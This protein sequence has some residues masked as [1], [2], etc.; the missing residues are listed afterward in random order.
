MATV[1]YKDAK[2]FVDGYDVSGDHNELTLEYNS[3]LQDE[4]SFGDSTRIR[5]GGLTTVRVSGSGFWDNASDSLV[6]DAY[7]G[8]LGTD[9]KVVTLFA[10]GISLGTSTDKGFSFKGV[11]SEYS[12][13]EA[14]GNLLGFS[15]AI[16]GRGIE[17]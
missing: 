12:V 10:D 3:E 6:S 14:V 8:L 17:A 1:I 16:D 2:I 13:G 15:V 5:K 4:T 7:F 11:I 9:D